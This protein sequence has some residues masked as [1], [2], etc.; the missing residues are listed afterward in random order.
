M[1]LVKLS[2]DS[3]FLNTNSMSA[4]GDLQCKSL[5]SNKGFSRTN[6]CHIH[7]LIKK[8]PTKGQKKQTNQWCC[9]HNPLQSSLL[10]TPHTCASSP[11]TVWSIFDIDSLGQPTAVSS[12]FLLSPPCLETYFPS[13]A[14]LP[15]GIEKSRTRPRPLNR[16]D[17]APVGSDV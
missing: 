17:A 2:D 3:A 15:P 16:E 11:T 12:L 7:G 8:Y 1:F 13:T 9:S 5:M 4:V 6:K 14:F 10:Q